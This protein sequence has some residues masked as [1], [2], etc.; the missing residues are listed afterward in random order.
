MK[1]LNKIGEELFSKLRGR[2][3]NITIGNAEGITTNMPSESRFYE[4]TY[5][6]QGGKVSVSLDEDGV[7]VMYSENLF[8]LL[9]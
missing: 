3:K 7:V 2:F 8:Q 6:D 9:F 1:D 5:G 4:F